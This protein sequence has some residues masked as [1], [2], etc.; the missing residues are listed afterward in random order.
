M[1]N[2]YNLM[3]VD[4]ETTG[5]DPKKGSIL[6]IAARILDKS[7]NVVSTFDGVLEIGDKQID[8]MDSYVF[9]MHLN[10]GLIYADQ[11]CT[12]DDFVEWAVQFGSL[13]LLGNSVGFD[14]QWLEHHCPV[15][16]ISYKMIDVSSIRRLHEHA[17]VVLPKGVESNHRAASDIDNC[18]SEAKFYLGKLL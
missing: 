17:G 11:N 16:P 13:R 8:Q 14:K 15:L 18:I 5:L 12:L 9:E 3:A 7:L 2:A 1:S 10:N 6:E 4:L